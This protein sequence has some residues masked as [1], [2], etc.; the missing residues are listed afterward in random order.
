MGYARL[1]I[2]GTVGVFALAIVG[3]TY[4]LGWS[5]APGPQVI[6]I[7]YE[8]CRI[9]EVE[10]FDL[11]FQAESHADCEMFNA[12]TLDQRLDGAMALELPSGDYVFRVTNRNAPYATGLWVREVGFDPSD[13]VDLLTKVSVVG[14]GAVRGASKDV[15]VTLLPGDYL[16]SGTAQSTPDYRLRVR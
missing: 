10:T 8:P 12:A 2:P 5:S 6:E 11:S 1:S 4:L 16:Y 3:A 14:H 15:N 9:V 13:P 7:T